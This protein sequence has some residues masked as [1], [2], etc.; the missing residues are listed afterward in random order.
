MHCCDKGL[1]EISLRD[2][3]RKVRCISSCCGGTIVIQASD[4]DGRKVPEPNLLQS[5]KSRKF[6]WRRFNLPCRKRRMQ[7]SDVAE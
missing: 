6:W 5:R 4:I 3:F 2:I 1:P 7:T